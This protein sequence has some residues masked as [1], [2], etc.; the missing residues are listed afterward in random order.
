M[1]FILAL[2]LAAIL[3]FT[4]FT[5]M[6]YAADALLGARHAHAAAIDAQTR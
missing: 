2:T 3:G 1:R 5:A 4:S 6:Q